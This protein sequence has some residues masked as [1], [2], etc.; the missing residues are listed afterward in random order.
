MPWAFNAS[1]TKEQCVAALETA[2]A[3]DDPSNADQYDRMRAIVKA[4]LE[5]YGDG[6]KGMSVAASGHSPG[7]GYSDRSFSIWISGSAEP[8]VEPAKQAEAPEHS[9]A[10]ASAPEP[11]QTRRR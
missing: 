7:P 6:S 3:P 1:G 9:E 11:R 10:P 8:R 4:E 5:R 2:A